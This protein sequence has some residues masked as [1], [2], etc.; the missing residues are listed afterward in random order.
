MSKQNQTKRSIISDSMKGT[1]MLDSTCLQEKQEKTEETYATRRMYSASIQAGD[2]D[3]QS[4]AHY[5]V[6]GYEALDVIRAKL[7][8]EEYRGY[9]KGNIL[10]YLM[11]SNYKQDHDKD[12]NKAAFYAA[13]LKDAL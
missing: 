4:P 3:I 2:C 12:C 13:E 11:R 7:T 10:K 6:G 1:T 5:T 8:P 9:L